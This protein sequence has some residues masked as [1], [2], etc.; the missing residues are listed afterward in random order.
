MKTNTLLVHMFG[1]CCTISGA[2]PGVRA[3]TAD[4]K[5]IYSVRELILLQTYFLFIKMFK[6][7]YY[8]V[9]FFLCIYN[10]KNWIWSP[11]EIALTIKKGHV[12]VVTLTVQPHNEMRTTPCYRSVREE[13]TARPSICLYFCTMSSLCCPPCK[14][15]KECMLAT[16]LPP[17]SPCEAEAGLRRARHFLLL[18]LQ[19]IT[20]LYQ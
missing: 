11:A 19:V 6:T 17:F 16:L 13:R 15:W 12:A 5:D 20:Q 3:L 4:F 14:N 18:E 10:W 8:Q 7:Q 1:A 2:A 9:K